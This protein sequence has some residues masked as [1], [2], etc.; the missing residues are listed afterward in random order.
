[1]LYLKRQEPQRPKAA[2]ATTERLIP[3]LLVGSLI[4]TQKSPPRTEVKND[5]ATRIGHVKPGPKKHI[6][7]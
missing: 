6:M 3:Y 5:A 2:L 7:S 1:V 4:K